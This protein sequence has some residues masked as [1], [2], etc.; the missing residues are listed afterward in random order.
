MTVPDRIWLQ[1]YDDL[2][3]ATWCQDRVDDEDAEY[4]LS[5]PP[6]EHAEELVEALG[7]MLLCYE[8]VP[9]NAIELGQRVKKYRALLAKIKEAS[10]E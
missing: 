7:A 1:N 4:I 6:R 9:M 3:E 10:N 5:T 2:Y 8:G